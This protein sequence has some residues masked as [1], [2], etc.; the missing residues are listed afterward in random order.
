MSTRFYR[1]RAAGNAVRRQRRL[2]EVG[3]ERG[4]PPRVNVAK[5]MHN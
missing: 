2:V 1:C 5:I 3:L 4:D